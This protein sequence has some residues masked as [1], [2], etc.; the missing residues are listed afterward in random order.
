[1]NTN[2]AVAF[3]ISAVNIAKLCHEANREYCKMIGDNSQPSW[4]DA[5]EWQKKSAINGVKFHFDNPDAPAS[6]SHDSWLKEKQADGWRYAE[7]K[8]ADKKE[9]PCFVPYDK[10]PIQQQLKDYIFR[11]MVHAFIDS[12]V[13]VAFYMDAGTDA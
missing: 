10:L 12:K 6:A 1:M 9:H 11:S 7:V 3:G 4:E 2:S 13:P 5:P 8:N